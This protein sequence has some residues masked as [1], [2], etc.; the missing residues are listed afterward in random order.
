MGS[1][2]ENRYGIGPAPVGRMNRA[3]SGQD[4]RQA[5][6]LTLR[7]YTKGWSGL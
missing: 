7:V 4:V 6:E 5:R 1:S 2:T 3:L